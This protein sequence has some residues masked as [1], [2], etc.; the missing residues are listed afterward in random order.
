MRK[1]IYGLMMA[2]ITSNALALEYPIGKPIIQ[3]GMEIGVVYLQAI[4]MVP[5]GMMLDPKQADIHL[6]ADIHA[7]QNNVNG[8]AEGDWIPYLMIHYKIQKMNS[9]DKPI[10][11]MLMPMVANDGPHYGD[12][13]KLDGPGK[14]NLTYTIMPPSMAT[15]VE[16]GRHIDKETGVAEWFK[17]FETHYV[18]TFAGIGK[19]GGY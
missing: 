5:K 7:T 9:H 6:E 14:Y 10:K 4:E 16:F 1:I 15:P 12:N 2:F 11:G 3:N 18:F 17:P 19:K 13:V 8:F